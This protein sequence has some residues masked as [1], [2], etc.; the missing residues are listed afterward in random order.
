MSQQTFSEKKLL[1]A[2]G[3]HHLAA[4]SHT[5]LSSVCGDCDSDI[6][7][8]TT[9]GSRVP[10][11]TFRPVYWGWGR[12]S[13]SA[14]RACAHLSPW[15]LVTPD[16]TIDLSCNSKVYKA[17]QMSAIEPSSAFTFIFST[18]P[19]YCQKLN[20]RL[21]YMP[22]VIYRPHPLLTSDLSKN[23]YICDVSAL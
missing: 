13:H 4:F 5:P 14:N 6:V 2:N 9:G 17:I 18:E 22:F 3:V 16:D 15:S 20:I 23:I 19:Q 8:L 21:P 1:K 12:G 10:G 7:C 11:I